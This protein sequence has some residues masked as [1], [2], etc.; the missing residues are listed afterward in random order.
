MADPWTGAD[1][2]ATLAGTASQAV[3]AA[4]AVSGSADPADPQAG[5]RSG[6][7]APADQV[8]AAIMAERAAA[9]ASIAARFTAVDATAA[10]TAAEVAPATDALVVSRPDASG[11]ARRWETIDSNDNT[12]HSCLR[13]AYE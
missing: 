11:P 9:A 13:I 7:I 10:A 1:D 8:Q 5:T 3:V 2:A 6:A 12:T 4:E